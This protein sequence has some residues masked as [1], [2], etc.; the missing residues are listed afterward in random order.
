MKR[1]SSIRRGSKSPRGEPKKEE[2]KKEESKKKP[3]KTDDEA[4]SAIQKMWR[5]KPKA[6]KEEPKKEQSSGFFSKKPE[7]TDDE[8]ASAIQKNWRGKPKKP[9]GPAAM[10][11]AE[12]KQAKSSGLPGSSGMSRQQAATQVQKRYRGFS[13]R[14]G[15]GGPGV[16]GAIGGAMTGM[17]EN[18]NEK[19]LAMKFS[20]TI[21]AVEK[22]VSLGIRTA[23]ETDPWIPNKMASVV[24]PF[25][26]ATISEI[27]AR[28]LHNEMEMVG[29]GSSQIKELLS[30][31]SRA[32]EWPPPPPKWRLFRYLR[33]RFLYAVNSADRNLS[34]KTFKEPW[35][36]LVMLIMYAPP[37]FPIFGLSVLLWIW[38][39]LCIIAVEDEFTLFNFIA[40]FKSYAFIMCGI[41]PV[42][43]DFYQF[44]FTLSDASFFEAHTSPGLAGHHGKAA[45]ETSWVDFAD[46]VCHRGFVMVSTALCWIT[47][48]RYKALRKLHYGD[49]VGWY[50]PA[51][52]VDGKEIARTTREEQADLEAPPASPSRWERVDASIDPDNV[53][54]AIHTGD[55]DTGDREQELLMTWDVLVFVLHWVFGVLDVVFRQKE[56]PILFLFEPS[57]KTMLFEKFLVISLSIFAAP[58]VLWKMPG[59]GE[60]VHQFRP[61]GF[62]QSG[63]L[64]ISMSLGA[65][66]KKWAEEQGETGLLSKVAAAGKPKKNSKEML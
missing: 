54:A 59:L 22:G 51:V 17:A 56:N 12:Q 1:F 60:L 43:I 61:T 55:Q 64:R 34:Y 2:P 41:L 53:W 25:L 3:E 32:S 63:K 45:S 42:F 27:T 66:K 33:A 38:Y 20:I 21:K 39:W 19:G 24:E 14:K 49:E 18:I 5:G 52:K 29:R 46:M 6:K 40:S 7:K 48:L 11:A 23:I 44:Y 28:A 4:A 36:L 16:L 58:F 26:L 37:I 65:M 57:W 30:K 50:K 62:D 31:Q 10:T 9:D 8:A 13:I 15:K 47:F 35:M